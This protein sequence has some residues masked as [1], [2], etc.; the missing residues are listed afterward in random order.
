MR[1][2]RL[3]RA[4]VAAT[5]SVLASCSAPP[6]GQKPEL[7]LPGDVVERGHFVAKLG[8]F[9]AGSEDF[10]ITRTDAG[11]DLMAH[12]RPN[13]AFDTPTMLT[14]HV[15]PDFRFR[16]AG[17]RRLS[18]EQIVA[19]YAVK[20]GSIRAEAKE[21]GQPLPAQSLELPEGAIVTTPSYASDS[22]LVGAADLS[23]GETKTFQTVS[24]GYPSWRMSLAPLTLAREP[25]AK[26]QRPDGSTVTARSYSTRIQ[27]PKGASSGHIWTDQAG[28]VLEST[29]KLSLGTVV[30]TRE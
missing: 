27:T 3:V 4:L 22:F 30:A 21:A 12:C 17:W 14:V 1:C 5:L 13:S 6:A 28:V 18:R 11:Y 10:L 19:E 26:L 9:D 29:L 20:D 15:G 23:V 24:F 2:S 7:S 8:V 16:S 25:D